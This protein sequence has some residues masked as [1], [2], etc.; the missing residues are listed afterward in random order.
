L[1]LAGKKFGNYRAV[2]LIG[3]GGFGAVY[4]AEHPLMS[5][6]AAVKVLRPARAADMEF[7][8]RFFN[9]ARA[10]SAINHPNIVEIF[11]AGVTEE[12]TPY[13]LMELLHG[14]T[15]KDRLARTG[16]LPVNTA[17][18]MA[19]A[20]ASALAAAHRS[21]IV[22]RDFKPE[23]VFL[24]KDPEG[25][26]R[27]GQERVKILDFGIAKLTG[28]GTANVVR[29][30]VGSF[31]GSPRYVSPEQWL[32][33]REVDHRTDI[34]ALA[35]VL[36]EMITGQPP[37][38]A[39]DLIELR[40]M[41]LGAPPP[42]LAD[43]GVVDA[44]PEL[45][46]AIARAL[47]K[48]PDQRFASADEMG[49]LLARLAG[50][51]PAM[52][53]LPPRPASRP[54]EP[55]YGGAGAT[56]GTTLTGSTGESTDAP[57]VDRERHP[58]GSQR[59]LRGRRVLRRGL[60]VALGT[61]S[62]LLVGLLITRGRTSTRDQ[63]TTAPPAPPTDRSVTAPGPPSSD[64]LGNPVM[65]AEPPAVPASASGAAAAGD[66][67]LSLRIRTRPSGATVVDEDTGQV[68]GRT[69]AELNF[70]AGAE[71]RR[72]RLMKRG[73]RAVSFEPGAGQPRGGAASP[74]PPRQVRKEVTLQPAPPPHRSTP[75]EGDIVL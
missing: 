57:A 40:Q 67:G 44:A 68:L 45:E 52:T 11:D 22:H 34:Y 63:T 30:E 70:A 9:E 36:F 35:A 1:D 12:G 28:F 42:R 54:T 43:R 53:S 31:M 3:E 55:L 48:D 72:V 6:K 21:G 24:A 66:G 25:S 59:A 14:E 41:H 5:R 26:G 29:T 7:L 2:S 17:L 33:T 61:A 51:A 75:L 13:L 62:L 69:P 73:Y 65:R 39:S 4:L 56:G 64:G 32:A 8:T 49:A 37:F 71:P 10:A 46:A 18:G 19:V 27:T 20:C 15:L 47:A 38:D 23:N 16:A 50:V 74:A 58:S 60:A